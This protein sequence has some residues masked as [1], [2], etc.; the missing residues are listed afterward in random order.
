MDIRTRW[1]FN[2]VAFCKDEIIVKVPIIL[3]VEGI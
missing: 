1:G 2:H 3:E